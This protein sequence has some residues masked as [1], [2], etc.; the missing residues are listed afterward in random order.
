MEALATFVTISAV[1]ITCGDAEHCPLPGTECRPDGPWPQT[2]CDQ[3]MN[4][5]ACD[6]AMTT[7]ACNP[8]G[9]PKMTDL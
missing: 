5:T 3:L 2:K 1:L 9:R 6:A 7:P 4:Q 8:K